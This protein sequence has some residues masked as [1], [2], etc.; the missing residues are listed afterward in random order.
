M[1]ERPARLVTVQWIATPF[2]GEQFAEAW[3]PAAEAAMNYGATGFALL[4]SHD[5]HLAF[6][7]LAF[8]D[9]ELDWERYWYSEE[10]S[11]ARAAAHGLFQLPVTPMWHDVVDMRSLPLAAEERTT[12]PPT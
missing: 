9:D 11:D 3:R 4:R 7:Q 6:T 12:D 1:S 10:I 5:D 2:R 8:F